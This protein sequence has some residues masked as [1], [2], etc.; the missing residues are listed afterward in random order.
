MYVSKNNNY[1]KYF[2]N[3]QNKTQQSIWKKTEE[4]YRIEVYAKERVD[5]LKSKN[6]IRNVTINRKDDYLIISYEIDVSFRE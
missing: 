2:Y 1:K 6:Y 3:K 5:L 4:K